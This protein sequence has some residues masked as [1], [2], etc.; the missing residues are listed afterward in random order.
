MPSFEWRRGGVMCYD[1]KL[2]GVGVVGMLL[3][4]ILDG[5][6]LTILGTPQCT[7]GTY[8][9]GFAQRCYGRDQH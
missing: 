6:P 9:L 8:Q 5:I 1:R 7:T 2:E 4:S 3:E